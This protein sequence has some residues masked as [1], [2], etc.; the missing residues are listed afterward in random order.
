MTVMPKSFLE[1]ASCQATPSGKKMD[2]GDEDG[3]ADD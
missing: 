2:D 3:R 1:R